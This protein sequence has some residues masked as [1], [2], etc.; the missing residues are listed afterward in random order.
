MP[1]RVSS[2]IKVLSILHFVMFLGQL[3]FGIIAFFLVYANNF[4]LP[5]I[6]EYTSFIMSVCIILATS[7]YVTGGIIFKRRVERINR[8]YK[9]LHQKLNEYRGASI[10]R[11]ALLEFAILFSLILY[12]LAGNYVII[13]I[14]VVLMFLFISCRPTSQKIA[15]DLKINDTELA[16]IKQ[17]TFFV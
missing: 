15:S 17:R 13:I 7:A 16:Q 8:E 6:V 3:L 5:Q 10:V 12:M 2:E 14:P 9:P 1:Q 11:W 4:F